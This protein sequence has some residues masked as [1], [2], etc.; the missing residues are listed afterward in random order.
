MVIS[1][2]IRAEDIDAG[3]NSVV[4]YELVDDADGLVKIDQNTGGSP[5]CGSFATTVLNNF[6]EYILHVKSLFHQS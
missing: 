3:D 4:T 2:N 1:V 6:G 5:I